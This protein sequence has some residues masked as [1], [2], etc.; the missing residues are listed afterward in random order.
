MN[1]LERA[2]REFEETTIGTTA[3]SAERSL[4]ALTAVPRASTSQVTSL[5]N[6]SNGS[7]RTGNFQKFDGRAGIRELAGQRDGDAANCAEC[8]HFDPDPAN[9]DGGLG[10]C[11]LS[12]RRLSPGRAACSRFGGSHENP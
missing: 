5:F 11:A 2:R 6:G 7:A 12:G 8:R 3:N 10:G 1:W 9:P 4:T